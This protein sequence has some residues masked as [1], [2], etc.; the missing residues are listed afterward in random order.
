M[1]RRQLVEGNQ[2]PNTGDHMCTIVVW[3][4]EEL[5]P[6]NA[7]VPRSP[8][9]WVEYSILKKTFHFEDKRGIIETK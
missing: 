1:T 7:A 3:E 8:R 9:T 6:S 2:D 4:D 5:S